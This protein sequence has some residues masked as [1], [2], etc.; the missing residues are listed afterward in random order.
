[1]AEAAEAAAAARARRNQRTFQVLFASAL[2]NAC[3]VCSTLTVRPELVARVLGNDPALI[4]KTTANWLAAGSALQLLVAPTLG[5]MSDAFGRKPVLLLGAIVSLA[6]R[7]AAMLRPTYWPLAL[8]KIVP[9]GINYY[10]Q[11]AVANAAIADLTET[12][13][14]LASTFGTFMSYLGIGTLLSPLV[15]AQVITMTGNPVHAYT[16]CAVWNALLILTYVTSFTET[17][18]K[19]KRREFLGSL[20]LPFS[21][22]SA[23]GILRTA[24]AS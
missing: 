8:E 1:M 5:K 6:L 9:Q 23:L 16:T 22:F 10:S 14:E 2:F 15:S 18:P 7:I 13:E 21:A 19:E 24:S 11:W 20:G 4:G 12:T 17:L 3:T